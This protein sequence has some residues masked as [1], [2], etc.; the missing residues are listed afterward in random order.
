MHL[1][2]KNSLINKEEIIKS[3]YEKV[4]FLSPYLNK[5]IV[6]KYHIV[7]T[8]EKNIRNIISFKKDVKKLILR[9]NLLDRVENNKIFYE[10]KVKIKKNIKKKIYEKLIDTNQL[11]KISDGIYSYQGD[12]L[13]KFKKLDNFLLNYGRK[14]NYKELHVND[15]LPIESI[16]ENDYV[17]NF[18]NH[19]I[20]L[21]NIRRNITTLDEISNSKKLNKNFIG[22]KLEKPFLVLSPTVCYHC[23]EMKKNSNIKKNVVYNLLAKC[24]RY[25]SKNYKTLERL[26]TFTMREYVSYG[27]KKYV[28]DFLRLNLKKFINIF[29]KLY[30]KFRVISAS[31]PFF[32]EAG[33]KKIFYQSA[34]TLKYEMQ[35]YL[36]EEKKW[37]AVG[38]F[39]NHLDLLTKK[40]QIKDKSKFIY[41]GCIGFGYER[42][43]YSLI[44]QGK[45]L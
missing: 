27:S 44:S 26:Q 20:F 2:I 32:S 14:L 40:Y 42:L 30:I 3:F 45:K 1:K 24:N 38:S 36:P 39:N 31:D 4:Y 41:S 19:P 33:I 13:N 10:N 6:N 37:L 9:V 28:N 8:F 22:S 29:K 25:E 17:S 15:T 11:V 16:L 5:C 23:F 7:F 21:S 43:L 12:F 18:P 34:Q 35:F